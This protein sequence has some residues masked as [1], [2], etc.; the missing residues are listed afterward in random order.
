MLVVSDTA[1]VRARAHLG[2]LS[3]LRALFEEVNL[4]PGVA[5][6]LAA[7]HPQFPALDVATIPFFRIRAPASTAGVSDPAG[8]LHAAKSTSS[9]GRTW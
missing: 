7:P 5:A 3:T 2:L 1:P 6:E 9:L 8:K 4:P